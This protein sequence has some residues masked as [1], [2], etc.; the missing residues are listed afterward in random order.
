[1]GYT[2][3]IKFDTDRELTQEEIAILERV[4]IA[5]VE[6]PVVDDSEQGYIDADYSTTN[7]EIATA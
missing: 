7:V 3:T 5:Q 2:I 1:M 6:E 4:V